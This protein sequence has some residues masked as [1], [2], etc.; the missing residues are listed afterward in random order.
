MPDA[1]WEHDANSVFDALYRDYLL[2]DFFAKI[3][4][5]SSYVALSAYAIGRFGRL[6]EMSFA[7]SMFLAGLSW[8]IGFAIQEAAERLSLLSQHPARF[9]NSEQRY[10]FR[11]KFSLAAS[12]DEKTRVERYAVIK[13][14]TGNLCMA[15]ISGSVLVAVLRWKELR[16]HPHPSLA[17]A[18]SLLAACWFLAL[19]SRDHMKKEYDFMAR[20]L[21]RQ[22]GNQD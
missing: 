6:L 21:R 16:E 12:R 3:V 5:G 15:L 2:R 10:D 18:F 13:E 11:Q 1:Q 20:A 22:S 7:V 14:A 19:A 8:A 9:S 17:M 4:P